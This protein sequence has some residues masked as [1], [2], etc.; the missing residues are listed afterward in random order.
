M[1][2]LSISFC[3]LHLLSVW[4][5]DHFCPL[6]FPVLFYN[7][8]PCPSGVTYGV[9]VHKRCGLILF[10]IRYFSIVHIR[11]RFFNNIEKFP[12]FIQS[13]IWK[14]PLDGSMFFTYYRWLRLC[15]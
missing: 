11:E 8:D 9:L 6:L 14:T 5:I 4:V 2:L 13:V 12:V 10:I 3:A 7:K 15:Q 1:F